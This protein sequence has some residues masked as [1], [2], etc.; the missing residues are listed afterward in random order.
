MSEA[1]EVVE[2]ITLRSLILHGFSV[3]ANVVNGMPWS[4][5]YHGIP[6]SHE[7]DNLYLISPPDRPT[8][9]LGRNGVL[10]T[11]LSG[12]MLVMEAP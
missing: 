6:V 11:M 4:F 2:A 3:G 12:K 8:L 7:N 9:R 5:N 1:D 10:V